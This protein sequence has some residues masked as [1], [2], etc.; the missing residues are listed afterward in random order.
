MICITVRISFT[1]NITTQ[2]EFILEKKQL[3]IFFP[4]IDLEFSKFFENHFSDN[5]VKKIKYNFLNFP[6]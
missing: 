4:L 6:F 3:L 1:Y 5:Y 2:Y